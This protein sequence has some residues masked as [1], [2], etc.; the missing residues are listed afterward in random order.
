M[1]MRRKAAAGARLGIKAVL[2]DDGTIEL[3]EGGKTASPDYRM[4]A[5]DERILIREYSK[6]K[7]K[8]M[9]TFSES[10]GA[11][12]DSRF[13]QQASRLSLLEDSRGNALSF[14]DGF[15]QL[16]LL[17]H[18]KDGGYAFT[19]HIPGIEGD[20]RT[21]AEDMVLIEDGIYEIMW[22]GDD[23]PSLFALV[24][25][26]IRREDLELFLSILLS[27]YDLLKVSVDGFQS[28]ERKPLAAS[29]ALI[30]QEVDEYGYL[31]VLADAHIEGLPTGA[32][33]EKGLTRVARVDEDARTL[34]I[35]DII[36][37][38]DPAAALRKLLGKEAKG[39]VYE[40]NGNFIIEGGFAEKFLS[41]RFQKLLD[42]FALYHPELLSHYRIRYARPKVHFRF[43][44]GIDF[45][46]GEGTVELDGETM[47]L[48]SFLQSYRQNDGYI[49]LNDKSRTYIDEEFIRKLQ[50]IVRTKDGKAIVSAYDIPYIEELEDVSATGDALK[51]IKEFYRGLNSIKD[52]PCGTRLKVSELRDYQKDGYRW[53][54]YLHDKGMGGCLADEMGLGKTVQIIALLNDV[55]ASR[56]DKPSLLIV[57]RSIIYSWLSEITKFGIGLRPF[58]YYGHDRDNDGIRRMQGGLVISSYATVRN[59]IA[60]IRDIE[61]DYV[62]ID[63]SQTVKHFG[64]QTAQAV[65]SLKAEHRIAVSG[66]P[67]ENDLGELYSLFRFLNPALFPSL[68]AFERDYVR[69]I[70]QDEDKEAEKELRMRIYP[71]I[72]RR[73][74]KDVLKDL[75]E[76]TEQV[77][78]IDMEDEHW[79]HYE[80]RRLEM[81]ARIEEEMSSVGVRKSAFII[82]QALTELRQIAALPEGKMETGT[83]SAKR[84]YLREVIPE[85][86][87]NGHKALIFTSFLDTVEKLSEDLD[88]MGIR[89]VAMTGATR[90][91]E[92]LVSQFQ[93]DPD[94]KVFLMTL[95][96]GG[97]GLNLTAADYVFIFD[98]WWNAA[99][100]EQAINRTHRIGQPNPVFCYRLISRGTIEEKMLE[101]QAKKQKLSSSLISSNG[102]AL[103]NLTEDEI[104]ELLG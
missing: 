89:F 52:I 61:F 2:Q 80:R 47:T 29:P 74:K 96:T 64:T 78:Y 58:V 4:A 30:F 92:K 45:L 31:H 41:E 69:P 62:I 104:R 17:A 63:E 35:R 102:D 40:E 53:L 42:G 8:S 37:T 32:I 24:D 55:S 1:L 34:E 71:F 81:K 91:R 15:Y 23:L 33:T 87:A 3:I 26:R 88:E 76:K 82:L 56:R 77:T 49:L 51:N 100:E 70:M 83:I 5:G 6:L 14:K 9:W 13:L 59:D 7:E 98:P 65:L 86:T 43:S 90:D 50:R 28:V 54:R 79:K 99:A 19:L 22:T 72:L 68:S 67:I 20:I 85:I 27:H 12:P 38:S 97:V 48:D 39:N 21:I 73:M 66:T 60:M 101:L 25:Q 103:K 75:P 95:K 16:E 18:E 93:S 94:T 44:S 57:P 46:E 10:L 84:E 11:M 36:L